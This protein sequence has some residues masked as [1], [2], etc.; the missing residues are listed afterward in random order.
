MRGKKW[1]PCPGPVYWVKVGDRT[2]DSPVGRTRGV[3]PPSPCEQTNK[4]KTLPSR[5]TTYTGGNNN[6]LARSILNV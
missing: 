2:R 3:T 6:A 1:E 4:L 5:H